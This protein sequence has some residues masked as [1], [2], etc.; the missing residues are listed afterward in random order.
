[1][2]IITEI[3]EQGITIGEKT[4][5]LRPSFRAM[6]RLGE[7]DE[8]VEIFAA[9]HKPPNFI[10]HM[11]WDG[12][13][14]RSAG[15]TVSRTVFK[16]YWLEMLYLSRDVMIAC[17][18][19]DLTP[20]IGEPGSRYGSY[21]IG[22]VSPEIMLAMARSLMQHGCIGPVAKA[23]QRSE[24]SG[25]K[26]GYTREFNALGFVSKAIA[27]LGVTESD[28]WNMTMSSFHAHWEAKYGEPKEARYVD[29]HEA[30]MSWLAKVNAIRDKGKTNG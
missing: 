13:G 5:I 7:P 8:I 3:G 30:T 14:V 28:A 23:V 1:M 2:H 15:D 18:D 12:V 24:R 11:E 10:E 29:E 22:P 27:N 9:I 25:S 21:R 4:Y 16:R 17:C 26:S 20:A 6:T 19:E